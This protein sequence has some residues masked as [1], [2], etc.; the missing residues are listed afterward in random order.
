MHLP[1][2]PTTQILEGFELITAEAAEFGET[3]ARFVSYFKKQWIEHPES[4]I[5]RFLLPYFSGEKMLIVFFIML[6]YLSHIFQEGLLAISV[7]GLSNRT[8]NLVESHNA[9]L[10]TNINPGLLFFRFVT[11]LAMEELR[12]GLQLEQLLD[13]FR[14]VFDKPKAAYENRTKRIESAQK[15]LQRSKLSVNQFLVTLS[16]DATASV[17]VNYMGNN[18]D[19][20]TDDETETM[21]LCQ[22]CSA[23]QASIRMKPCMHCVYCMQ[24]F[25]ALQGAV[26]SGAVVPC[27]IVKCSHKT[28]GFA[29]N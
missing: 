3:F 20:E 21:E 22:R 11:L 29:S 6:F 12:K 13:G 14:G 25:L 26:T 7:F 18:G 27:P 24:C 2:L 10:S 17:E 8:N 16:R 23:Q 4:T 19:S 5:F 15:D 1:L 9:R 28:T